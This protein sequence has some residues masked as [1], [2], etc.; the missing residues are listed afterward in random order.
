[1]V[2]GGPPSYCSALPQQGFLVGSAR[3]RGCTAS[4]WLYHSVRPSGESTCL[5]CRVN[6]SEK[7]ETTEHSSRDCFSPNACK[8]KIRQEATV[9]PREQPGHGHGMPGILLLAYHR[10]AL[11]LWPPPP[12]VFSTLSTAFC[13]ITLEAHRRFFL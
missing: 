4:M 9:I 3:G 5:M 2:P 1:M 12:L 7:R 11:R 10:P 6:L 8:K 13:I